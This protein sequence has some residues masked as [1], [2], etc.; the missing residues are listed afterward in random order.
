MEI[1]TRWVVGF[2][3]TLHDERHSPRQCRRFHANPV[4]GLW[5]T[6]LC[7]VNE[8]NAHSWIVPW[9]VQ[10]LN[11]TV[12][13]AV[14]LL[15]FTAWM[16]LGWFVG[17]SRDVRWMR[18][19]CA[20]IFVVMV[21]LVCLGGGAWISRRMTQSSYRESLTNLSRLLNE[22]AGEGRLEDVRD[23]ITHLADEPDE[24][25]TNSPDILKRIDE[26]TI[27][28]QKTARK[29]VAAKPNATN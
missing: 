4:M 25:S 15:L 6:R 14:F 7:P 2:K 16:L 27:A 3:Q 13:I 1:R 5:L 29:K 12:L 8:P 20:A 22:R 19:W 10:A 23:A 18:N 17:E 21:I 24:W 11:M 26:V 28:L 9:F